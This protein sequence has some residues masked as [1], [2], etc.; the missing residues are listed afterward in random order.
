VAKNF[1]D[2]SEQ[3]ILALPISSEETDVQ[4]YADFAAGCSSRGNPLIRSA[5]AKQLIANAHTVG[6]GVG[7]TQSYNSNE[8]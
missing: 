6:R 7:P 3:E 5:W 1:K 2:L 4:I 8:E